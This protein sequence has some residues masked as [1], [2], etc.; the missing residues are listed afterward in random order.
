MKHAALCRVQKYKWKK[1]QQISSSAFES[2]LC[3]DAVGKQNKADT[4]VLMNDSRVS[5]KT[6]RESLC[7]MVIDAKTSKAMSHLL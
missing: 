5:Q 2:I 3:T 4:G 7:C 6:V 1:K